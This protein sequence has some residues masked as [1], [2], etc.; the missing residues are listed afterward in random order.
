MSEWNY[1]ERIY[2]EVAPRVRL[3][4]PPRAA[5][6]LESPVL[7]PSSE[8]GDRPWPVGFQTARA[9]GAESH[10]GDPRGVN[11]RQHWAHTWYDLGSYC[12]IFHIVLVFWV[13]VAG[14]VKLNN[15][16]LQ[17]ISSSKDSFNFLP[18]SQVLFLLSMFWWDERECLTLWLLRQ[19]NLLKQGKQHKVMAWSLFWP[20]FL[21]SNNL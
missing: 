16:F 11:L 5:H 4:K 14:Y 15:P 9:Y 6:R 20:F 10:N 12:Q 1:L 3:Y 13:E 19:Q 8:R 7:G 21:V 18:K 17:P 2:A